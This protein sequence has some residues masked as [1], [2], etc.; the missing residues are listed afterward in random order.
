MSES[1]ASEATAIMPKELDQSWIS[2][3]GWKPNLLTARTPCEA[4]NL[5]LN[6]LYFK[7]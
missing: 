2:A 5:A 6:I 3:C 7:N 4:E 1:G